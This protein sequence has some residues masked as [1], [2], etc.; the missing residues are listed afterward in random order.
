M[1]DDGTTLDFDRCLS[2]AG[3]FTVIREV[4]ELSQELNFE[5]VFLS[6]L[7]RDTIRSTQSLHRLPEVKFV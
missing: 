3:H 7:E 2:G 6:R 5:T 1:V 4:P